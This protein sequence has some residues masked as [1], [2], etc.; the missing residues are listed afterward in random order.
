M[1]KGAWWATDHGVTG[2]RHDWATEYAYMHWT[3][4]RCQQYTSFLPPGCDNQNISRYCQM[5][6]QEQ[7][8]QAEWK[9]PQTPI[10]EL[11]VQKDQ[12]D[13]LYQYFICWQ[14]L[15]KFLQNTYSFRIQYWHFWCQT[16]KIL[17]MKKDKSKVNLLLKV[18]ACVTQ[19]ESWV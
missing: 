4:P 18:K 13:R 10:W 1:D 8:Q 11:E 14:G 3:L 12:K 2:V 6:P 7:N 16:S 19:L 15:G 5:S 17:Q 9:T